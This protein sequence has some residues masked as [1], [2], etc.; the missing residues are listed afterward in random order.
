MHGMM[1]QRNLLS[2]VVCTGHGKWFYRLTNADGKVWLMPARN[3]RV[4]MGLYQP[5]GMKGK[6][7]KVMFPYLHGI[8]LVNRVIRAERMKYQLQK[9]YDKLIN[10]IFHIS[11]PEFSIFLGTPSARQKMTIQV[12][13]GTQIL[14]YIKVAQNEE[15]NI[16]FEK[17]S[18]M[19]AFL[20]SK[21]IEYIPIPLFCGKVADDF[22][23]VQST[24]KTC[25]SNVWH[26]W[27]SL[28]AD[29]VMRLHQNTTLHIPF[30]ETEFYAELSYLKSHIAQIALKDKT[31]FQKSIEIVNN[32]FETKDEYSCLHADFT[33]WNMFVDRSHLCVFDFEYSGY[34]YPPYMDM[35]HYQLQLFLL[36]RCYGIEKAFN[37]LEKFKSQILI[38]VE[39]A[40]MLIIAYL[41]HIL[42]FYMQLYNGHFD[43]SDRM[44]VIWTG[45][46]EKYINQNNRK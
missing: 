34:T 29:F 8:G 37:G 14:G 5:S 24:Y 1:N 38:H 6:L 7:L 12:S 4:A 35:V 15:I 40:D 36:E 43:S 3:M 30:V 16:L 45:L 22:V 31:L 9:K 18:K 13:K 42:S 44:Y 46:L 41:I 33:P 17:E 28:H 2:H 20:A 23:F 27:T 10:E 26:L 21:G 19:L 25:Q 32:Y 39:N 11:N